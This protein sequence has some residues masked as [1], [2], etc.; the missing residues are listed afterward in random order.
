MSSLLYPLLD[1][2]C[3]T[4]SVYALH[5]RGLGL[6]SERAAQERSRYLRIPAM[7]SRIFAVHITHTLPST[8]LYMNTDRE[9]VVIPSVQ[10]HTTHS[11]H[12]DADDTLLWVY[13]FALT[14]TKRKQTIDKHARGK[15]FRRASRVCSPR[16]CE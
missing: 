12:T 8:K 4:Q 13:M 10:K 1:I 9:K 16:I 2:A 14:S 7:S 3:S 6:R 5:T 15:A 11:H